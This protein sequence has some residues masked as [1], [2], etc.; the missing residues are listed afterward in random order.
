MQGGI[1][2]PKDK[3]PYIYALDDS[4]EK[5][6][7]IAYYENTKD[8]SYVDKAYAVDYTQRKMYSV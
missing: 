4:K 1:V 5:S 7:I 2:D 6:Q 3:T 8:L